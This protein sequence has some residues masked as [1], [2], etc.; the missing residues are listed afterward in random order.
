MRRVARTDNATTWNQTRRVLQSVRPRGPSK[1][2]EL[3]GRQDTASPLPRWIPP[4][5]CQPIEMA[6]SGLQ[7]LHE[8][9][10]DGFRM[11]ARIAPEHIQLLT[12]TGL[13]WS[14]KYPSIIA[15]LAKVRAK[16]AYLDGELTVTVLGRVADALKVDAAE[17]VKRSCNEQ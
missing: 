8:I 4:Q 3:R 7:W 12:R 1:S 17:L 6:L 11:W 13:D 10:L 16:T 2:N 15:A 14:D 5:H 9:K